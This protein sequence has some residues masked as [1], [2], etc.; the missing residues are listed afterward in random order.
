VT[1]GRIMRR[2]W[3]ISLVAGILATLGGVSFAATPIAVT[4]T[5]V[6]VRHGQTVRISGA[7]WAVI[8]FCKPRVTLTLRR[9]APLAPLAIATVPLRTGTANAGTFSTAWTVPASVHAGARTI[10]ATQRCES[11]KDGSLRLVRRTTSV[12]VR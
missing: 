8:E 2:W 11:G 12:H 10:I 4:A 6:S 5:P 3:R 9:A 7:G 1:G